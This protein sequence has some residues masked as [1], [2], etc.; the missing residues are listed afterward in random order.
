MAT[1]NDRKPFILPNSV[2]AVTDGSGKT[3]LLKTK[4]SEQEHLMW[5]RNGQSD[6]YSYYNSAPNPVR[7]S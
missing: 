1:Y 7:I 5:Y 3:T 2:N 6:T 4:S